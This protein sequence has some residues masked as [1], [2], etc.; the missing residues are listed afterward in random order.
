[1]PSDHEQLELDYGQTTGLI[2]DLADT[3][4]KLVA[5]VP[6]ISGAAVALLSQHPSPAQ[7]LAVGTLGLTA[8]V[9]VVIYELRNTQVYE[10]ALQRAA[11]LERTLE[12]PSTREPGQTG[13]VFSERP[14]RELR[15]FGLTVGQ[16]RGL[17]LVYAAAIGGWTYLLTWG[18][19]HLLGVH[20]SQRAGGLIAV[21]AAVFVL[22]EFLRLDNR[23]TTH[24]APRTAGPATAK[25]AR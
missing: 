24:A 12:I 20:H 19:L 15:L 3:R 18:G 5:L 7:L 2:R 16:E 21:L 23:V 10:Y 9:G 6:T 1:M 17:A 25:A 11:T 14:A 13:G 8:T 22:I 4:F